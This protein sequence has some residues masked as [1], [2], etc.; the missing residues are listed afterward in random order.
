MTNVMCNAKG[1][2]VHLDIGHEKPDLFLPMMENYPLLDIII[3][4]AYYFLATALKT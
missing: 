1:L 4:R 3:R 2:I